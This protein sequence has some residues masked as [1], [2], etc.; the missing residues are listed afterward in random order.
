MKMTLPHILLQT[1][2]SNDNV[3]PL[4]ELAGFSLR[5]L[6]VEKGITLQDNIL[7]EAPHLSKN[8]P[9]LPNVSRRI[10]RSKWR[11]LQSL[12]PN[13]HPDLKFNSRRVHL[14]SVQIIDQSK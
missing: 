11:I 7:K 8:S 3:F 5:I 12:M 14:H 13:E 10:L 6:V 2:P 4:T 9:K 1:E